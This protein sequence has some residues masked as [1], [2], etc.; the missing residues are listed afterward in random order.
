MCSPY[1]RDRSTCGTS[2][3]PV[4]Y[5]R[6][7]SHKRIERVKEG[8]RERHCAELVFITGGGG[9]SRYNTIEWLYQITNTGVEESYLVIVV[10]NCFG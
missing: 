10:I 9:S 4:L 3:P 2:F 6:I 7:V 5:H 1:A 8:E